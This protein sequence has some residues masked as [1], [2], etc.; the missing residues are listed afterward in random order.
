MV[1]E[2]HLLQQQLYIITKVSSSIDVNVVVKCYLVQRHFLVS[3][4]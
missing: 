3:P 2:N 1:I 4:Y